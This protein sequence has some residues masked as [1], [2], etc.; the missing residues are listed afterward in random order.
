MN[1]NARRVS[2]RVVAKLE[3]VLPG[4]VFATATL[5]AARAIVRAEIKRGVDLVI[6]GGGD[7]AFVMGLSLIAEACRGEGRP[8]P[9]VGILRLG[10]G[11]ALARTFGATD[12]PVDD[13]A[14]L[15]RSEGRWRSARMLEV[16]GMRTPFLG[17]GADADILSDQVAVG[18]LVD[19]VPGGR[20]ISAS[21]RYALSVGLRSIPRF[22]VGGIGSRT[23]A[24]ITNLGSPATAMDRSGPTGASSPA[25]TVL[26]T[27]SYTLIA[28][29]TIPYFGFGLK[30]F[31]YAESNADRFQLRC[32]DPKLLEVLR[33]T[34]ATFR[35]DYF[36]DRIRDFLCDRVS[37]E[38]SDEEGPEGVPIEA[39][40][41]LLGVARRIEVG[42]APL[43]TVATLG[44]DPSAP[45][46]LHTRH[47]R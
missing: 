35:G 36:S 44:A 8:E 37:I 24:V 3:R 33:N 12:D 47:Q 7:G 46:E 31:S 23:T 10:S 28:A 42:L 39:G 1:G 38:I 34:P 11:N 30:M 13:L 15:I 27:G 41:E 32:G 16:L 17:I 45:A 29:A 18:K 40:G 19:R 4:R 20:W 22:A 9:A 26:W 6:F 21:T 43:I 2:A 14:R 25:G 5:E